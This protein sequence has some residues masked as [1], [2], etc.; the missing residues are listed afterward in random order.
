MNPKAIK[1]SAEICIKV[2]STSV[3]VF[4]SPSFVDQNLSGVEG[5]DKM[6]AKQ[7]VG[8][9]SNKFFDDEEPELVANVVADRAHKIIKKVFN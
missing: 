5:F 7:K 8:A 2:Q 1:Q 3:F 9:A 6:K 4:R